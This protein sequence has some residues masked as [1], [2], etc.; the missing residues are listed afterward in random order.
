MYRKQPDDEFAAENRRCD[1]GQRKKRN[2][3]HAG[4][5]ISFKTVGRRTDRIASIVTRAIGDDAGI[6]WVIFRQV[7]DDFHQVRTDV[8]DFGENPAADAQHR[9]AERFANRK[10]DEA[11]P[12]E[13]RWD[14]QENADH[15]R[16]FDADE[17]QANAHAGLQ[18]DEKGLERVALERGKG[19]A[20]VGGSVDA[21]AEPRD[22]VAAEDAKN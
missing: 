5:A 6:F 3:S 19:G 11:R 16:Q 15:A 14:E 17:Q 10:A 7:K 9:C 12:G 4:H 8:G 21:D 1:Q 20:A 13:Q 18:R 2:Q 22:A